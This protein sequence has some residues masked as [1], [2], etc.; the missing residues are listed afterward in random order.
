MVL[1]CAKFDANGYTMIK[2]LDHELSYRIPK[3][4]PLSRV[5]LAR[6]ITI[7]RI[8]NAK[9]SRKYHALPR[10]GTGVIC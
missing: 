9:L 6:D 5:S 4:P 3:Q 2:L 8:L 7:V 1:N 10:L